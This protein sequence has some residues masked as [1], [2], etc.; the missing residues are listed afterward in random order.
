MIRKLMS[1][2]LWAWAGACALLMLGNIDQQT[3]LIVTGAYIGGQSVV[4]ALAALRT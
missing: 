2:K 1:R 4:D 3:W